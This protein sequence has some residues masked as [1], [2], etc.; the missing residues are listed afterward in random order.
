MKRLIAIASLSTALAIGTTAC[1]HKQLTKTHAV[2]VAATA[3]VI[4]G[5]VILSSQAQCGNCNIG[6]VEPALAPR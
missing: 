1:A 6:G 5:I 4:A 3:A 2:E